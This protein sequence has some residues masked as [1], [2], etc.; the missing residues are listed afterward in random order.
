MKF[1]RFYLSAGTKECINSCP[2]VIEH[3]DVQNSDPYRYFFCSR[4]S[5]IELRLHVLDYDAAVRFPG[6][7]SGR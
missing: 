6:S 2:Q 3:F 7:G 4:R 5:S 1:Y